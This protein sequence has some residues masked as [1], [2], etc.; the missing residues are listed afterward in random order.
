MCLHAGAVEIDGR[1]VVFPSGRRA[2]K[3]T[4]TAELTRRGYRLFSDDILAVALSDAGIAS[5]IATGISPRLR[6]PLPDTASEAFVRWVADDPGPFNSQYKYLTRA[7]VAAEGTIAP[8]AAIVTLRRLDG[9]TGLR[10]V[11]M[12]VSETLPILIHQNFGRFV[13]SGRALATFEAMARSLPCIRLEYGEFSD[14]V[15]WLERAASRDLLSRSAM[16]AAAAC[17]TADLEHDGERSFD[18]ARRYR[19]KN[20]FTAVEIDGE[21]F[22]AD[23][24]GT[25]IFR[26]NGSM[27]P[28]WVLLEE[29]LGPAE[30]VEL[31]QEAFPDI[32]P[33][34]LVTDVTGAMKSLRCAGLIEPV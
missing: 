33:G 12:N 5:G 21:A 13:H 26:L 17:G 4:L 28:I 11:S 9:P 31:F 8:I 6:L 14:A 32:A 24:A 27:L 20:G 34:T 25:G 29:P 16:V 23:G 10:G 3:S 15:D 1:L 7:P 19:R 2:G 18:S 30:V 22:V